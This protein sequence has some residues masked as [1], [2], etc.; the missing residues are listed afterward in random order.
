ML[1]IISPKT[2][3]KLVGGYGTAM[4]H[5]LAMAFNDPSMDDDLRSVLNVHEVVLDGEWL[6]VR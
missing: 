4:D 1:S 3:A 2:I 5:V 6:N